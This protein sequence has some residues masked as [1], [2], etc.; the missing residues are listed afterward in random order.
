[1]EQEYKRVEEDEIDLRELF[2][3]IW[4][5]R[6]FIVGFTAVVTIIALI[7]AFFIAKPVYEGRAVLEMGY[8]T[9]YKNTPDGYVA[10]QEPLDSVRRLSKELEILYI[11]VPKTQKGDP[12]A[13]GFVSVASVGAMKGQDNF[14]EIVLNA[15]DN[16]MI[17]SRVDEILAYINKKEKEK[18]DNQL[19][20]MNGKLKLIDEQIK[21]IEKSQGSGIPD[22]AKSDIEESIEAIDK[23]EAL[24]TRYPGKINLNID[25]AM[26][27]YV[28]SSKLESIELLKLK[29]QRENLVKTISDDGFKQTEIVGQI[30]LN[31]HPIKPKK[32]LIV[33]VAFVTGFILS[34]FL[35]FF[36]EFIKG[37]KEEEDK[38]P[39]KVS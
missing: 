26:L 30:L 33:V 36:M 25:S 20:A 4:K 17:T 31:D 7:Y 23:I 9:K 32:K 14:L 37:F 12:D 8:M 16:N 34:I 28:T 3:T 35:V 5:K 10:V 19:Q 27:E 11:E 38:E 24:S 22:G 1:M 13:K 6:F 15:S 2:K 29:E 18:I 39:S 21:I